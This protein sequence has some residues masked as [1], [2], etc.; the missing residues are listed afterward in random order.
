MYYLSAHCLSVSNGYVFIGFSLRMEIVDFSNDGTTSII[1]TFPIPGNQGYIAWDIE[2]IGD[3][4]Y[5]AAGNIWILDISNPTEPKELSQIGI[6]AYAQ[7]LIVM[8]TIMY[9]ACQDGS[10]PNNYSFLFIISIKQTNSRMV[11]LSKF[12]ARDSNRREGITYSRTDV[13]PRPD[14]GRYNSVTG[15]SIITEHARIINC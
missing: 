4:A 1:G 13:I 7:D 10:W 15:I 2:I 9:V 11:N 6:R 8:D 12:F 5:I 14:I 3:I